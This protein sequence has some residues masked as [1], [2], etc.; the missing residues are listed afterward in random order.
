MN[1]D[2]G[3]SLR[4][5]ARLSRG[6]FSLDARLDLDIGGVTGLFG[7]SGGGKSTLLRIIAGF[8]RGADAEIRFGEQTWQSRGKGAFVPPHQR[9][10]GYVFQDTRLFT[11]RSV[12]GNL[13]YAMKR[14]DDGG[15]EIEFED[16]VAAFDLQTLFARRVESLSGGERQRVA[17]ARTLL[18]RPQLLLLDE[19][20]AALDVGRKQEILPYLETLHS[21]FGIPTIY[22]SHSMDEVS[23]LAD[24]VVVLDAGK[25]RSV[26]S[27]FE[28]L[29]R[30][31]EE[32]PESGYEPVSVFEARVIEQ[33]PAM[34]LTRLALGEQSIVVPMMTDRSTS[35]TVVINVRAADV[36]LATSEPGTLSFRNVL[37][38]TVTNIHGEPDSAFAIVSVDIGGG[39]LKAH[40]T[41]H[42]V[43]ELGLRAGKPVYA[44]LKTASFDRRR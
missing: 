23:R 15:P 43:G 37:P 31:S 5:R 10:V 39:I 2:N 3:Q 35:E 7:P 26:G 1:A 32:W 11:H 8:E 4:V 41:R 25:V 9:P 33:D 44:L 42:A 6:R 27:V 28:V 12:A 17:I 24:R 38:G 30:L 19:P 14:A 21:R 13:A 34:N 20:L 18:A 22:V 16:V 40:L 36:A 29:N